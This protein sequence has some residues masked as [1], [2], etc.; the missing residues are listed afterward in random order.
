[1]KS[2]ITQD[3]SRYSYEII[4]VED[5]STDETAV[6]LDDYAKQYENIIVL[7]EDNQGV[8]VARNNGINAANGTYV[9]FVDSDDFIKE[10]I[11]GTIYRILKKTNCDCLSI[12][13]F[14]FLDGQMIDYSIISSKD[15]QC[16]Y[17]NFLWTKII[18]K[19]KIVENSIAF[20]SE[21]TYAEDCVFMMQLR[22]FLEHNERLDEIAY[23]YRQRSNSLM[24]Q[25]DEKKIKSRIKSALVCKDIINGRKV[26]DIEEATRYL[27]VF[28]SKAMGMISK[29]PQ[30]KRKEL[31]LELESNGVFPLKYSKRYTPNTV[32]KKESIK[33]RIIHKLNDY[34]YLKI[35]YMLL[36]L[37]HRA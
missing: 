1:M 14:S 13:S 3:V 20:N 30:Q 26:G 7:H 31:Y 22:P 5:G 34:S 2:L 32:K 16:Q 11:L 15:S 25:A 18:K 9:W 10:N 37:L 36:V 29:L 35:S 27:Y 24:S 33:K 4:C 12:L 21:I 23:F 17:K 8:S 19:D 28:V 6:L